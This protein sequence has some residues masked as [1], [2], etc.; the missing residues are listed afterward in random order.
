MQV[1]LFV[2]ECVNN[3][4]FG[5]HLILQELMLIKKP[6]LQDAYMCFLEVALTKLLSNDNSTNEM[7][8]FLFFSCLQSAYYSGIL[9][10]SHNYFI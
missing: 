8:N 10:I 1:T 3:I 4:H 5:H 6:S 2:L 7:G 9:F